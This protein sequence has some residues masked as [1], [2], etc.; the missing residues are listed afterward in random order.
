M[1]KKILSIFVDESGDFG[2]FCAHSPYYLVALIFHEQNVDISHNIESLDEH[3]KNLGYSKHNIHIGPLIRRE[4]VYTND[5]MENRK[6]LFNALFNFARKINFH[7]TYTLIK[8]SE[9]NGI[10]SLIDRQS[11]AILEQLRVN[12]QYLASFDKIIVYYDNGQVELTKI[13]ISIFYSLF[14]NVEFRKVRPKDYKLFQVADLVCAMELLA[15]KAENNSFTHSEMEFFG[16]IRD[17]KKNYYKW[18]KKKL[19]S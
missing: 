4:L 3:I 19:L 2:T 13:L 10:L 1:S 16:G 8:K 15:K 18:I 17:F 6:K 12:Q 11:K 7:Y 14:S 5:L 9:C